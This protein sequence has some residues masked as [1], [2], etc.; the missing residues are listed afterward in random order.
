MS[1]VT[2]QIIGSIARE[3]GFYLAC[4]SMLWM[5]LYV[6]IG[7]IFARDQSWEEP[8]NYSKRYTVNMSEKGIEYSMPIN[9]EI[10]GSISPL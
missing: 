4:I 10:E 8:E 3:Y 1:T 2:A 5:V 7:I 6:I 9:Q